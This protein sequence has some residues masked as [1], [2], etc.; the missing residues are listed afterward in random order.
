MKKQLTLLLIFGIAL[1][2]SVANASHFRGGAANAS[3]DANGLLTIS[4]TSFWR[5]GTA[6]SSYTYSSSAGNI[7]TNGTI[8][9]SDARFDVATTTGTLQ[10]PGAG[11]YTYNYTSCCRVG[12]GINFAENDFD[13]EGA[14]YW[15]GSTANA[16]IL[17][18]F[19]SVSN[20]VVAGTDYNQNLNAVGVGLTYDQALNTFINTQ[21]PGFTVDPVTG[22]MH[23]PAAST[24][25]YGQNTSNDGAD[26]AFSGNIKAADGSFTQF[27]WVFDVVTS[28]S[29]LAPNIVDMVIDG[30][31]GD[32]LSGTLVGADPEGNTLNWFVQSLIGAGINMSNFTF[33]TLTQAFS[34]DT[35]GLNVGQY[36]ANIGA[37]DGALNG[38][39]SITFNLTNAPTTSV[40][41][42]STILLFGLATALLMRTRKAK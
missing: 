18:D 40:P 26:Y 34:F 24:S 31:V 15:D 2:S 35:T 10:L 9:T 20:E 7:Y 3:V 6:D 36:I 21:P 27:D 41:E 12:G 11:L 8:N 37:S 25:T 17:F 33:D 23:I 42:P 38:F 28:A 4:Q 30:L 16:P 14:I 29:N 1:A 22:A 5:K 32:T 19:A 39:G 13:V